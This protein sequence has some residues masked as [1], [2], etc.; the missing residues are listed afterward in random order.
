MYLQLTNK[1]ELL[2]FGQKEGPFDNACIYVEPLV[3]D[4]RSVADYRLVSPAWAVIRACASRV[5][6]DCG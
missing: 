2:A 5:V 4:S 1:T 3:R 6:L